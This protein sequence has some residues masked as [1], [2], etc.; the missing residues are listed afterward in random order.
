ME[1]QLRFMA[2]QGVDVIVTK[3]LAYGPTGRTYLTAEI[4]AR[5]RRAAIRSTRPTGKN[6][7]IVRR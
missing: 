4:V 3:R 2:D 7:D 5:I 1:A 6:R